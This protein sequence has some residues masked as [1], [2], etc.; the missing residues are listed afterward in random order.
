MNV[1]ISNAGLT[2][3]LLNLLVFDYVLDMGRRWSM[4]G[5]QAILS[6]RS[7][8]RSGRFDRSWEYIVEELKGR[9]PTNENWNPWHEKKKGA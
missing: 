3:M 9:K 2:I 6:I 4:A 5:V 7:L 8:I 1:S